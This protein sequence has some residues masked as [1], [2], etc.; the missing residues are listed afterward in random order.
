HQRLA[1]AHV[2]VV[3]AEVDAV[4]E[5]LLE[6]GPRAVI[7][8]GAAHADVA[9]MP[10]IHRGLELALERQGEEAMR[11]GERGFDRGVRNTVPRN[12]EEADLDRCAANRGSHGR[13]AGAA[14]GRREI[15]D[16]NLAEIDGAGGG[17]RHGQRYPAT[18]RS[19]LSGG[20]R[21]SVSPSVVTPR[22]LSRR[23]E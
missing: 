22:P 17:V 3:L 14:L 21:P 5:A 13:E 10:A 23:F 19:A 18:A 20:D 7:H 12:V 2:R 11:G 15:D 4:D 16:G 6:I 1:R 9:A 8:L